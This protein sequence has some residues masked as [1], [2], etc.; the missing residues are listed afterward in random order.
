[1][2]NITFNKFMKLFLRL[3]LTINIDNL[4]NITYLLV[5]RLD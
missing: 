3:F 5:C 4:M 1:L 2:L